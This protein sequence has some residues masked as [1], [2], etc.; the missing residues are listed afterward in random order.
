MMWC[1]S[2]SVGAV[3]NDSTVSVVSF[4]IAGTLK[5]KVGAALPSLRPLGHQK[6]D[7]TSRESWEVL[8]VDSVGRWSGRQEV[9]SVQISY[10]TRSKQRLGIKI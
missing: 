7:L 3:H 4:D 10:F 9:T 5:Q 6:G 2:V 1:F 8:A